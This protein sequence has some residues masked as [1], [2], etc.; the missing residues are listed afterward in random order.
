MLAH[1]KLE[2][3]R[4]LYGSDFKEPQKRFESRQKADVAEEMEAEI[5][6]NKKKQTN[7]E[8]AERIQRDQDDDSEDDKEAVIQMLETAKRTYENVMAPNFSFRNI[9]S[10]MF[11]FVLTICS[12]EI[13]TTKR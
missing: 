12:L 4:V 9:V 5:L 13:Q 2:A 10:R 7:S 8:L 1:L 11:S 3:Q 6:R